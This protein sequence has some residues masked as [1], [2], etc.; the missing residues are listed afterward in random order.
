M[1]AIV[2][3]D[4]RPMREICDYV[5]EI[6]IAI[7]IIA[8]T[9]SRYVVSCPTRPSRADETGGIINTILLNYFEAGHLNADS[10]V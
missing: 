3:E 7:Q 6:I 9:K 2:E 5:Y 1:D 4:R 8:P 10:L